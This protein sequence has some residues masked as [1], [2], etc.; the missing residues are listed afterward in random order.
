M[1]CRSYQ[2]DL[3]VGAVVH[4]QHKGSWTFTMAHLTVCCRFYQSSTSASPGHG[5]CCT[6]ST[7]VHEHLRWRISLCAAVF[8]SQAL[9]ITDSPN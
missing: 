7:R 9:V 1:C 8:I 5:C 2:P 4:K 6:S 3:A